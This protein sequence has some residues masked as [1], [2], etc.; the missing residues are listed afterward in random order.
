MA[1]YPSISLEKTWEYNDGKWF[2]LRVFINSL[3]NGASWEYLYKFIFKFF[4][5]SLPGELYNLKIKA[6]ATA[7]IHDVFGELATCTQ[8]DV[9][10]LQKE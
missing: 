2:F 3:N 7:I 9:D 10:F 8:Q 5:F 4:L 1:Q 6:C